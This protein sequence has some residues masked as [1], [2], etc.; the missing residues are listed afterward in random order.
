MTSADWILFL[1]LVALVCRYIY[2]TQFV[3]LPV[4]IPNYI[5]SCAV[6][7][8]PYQNDSLSN[9]SVLTDCNIT[10][11]QSIKSALLTEA[12]NTPNVI[13]SED[14]IKV[15]KSDDDGFWTRHPN[16]SCKSGEPVTFGFSRFDTGTWMIK[17]GNDDKCCPDQEN[18]R[19][20]L[21]KLEIPEPT[22]GPIKKFGPEI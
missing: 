18:A 22:Y 12:E 13:P 15:L 19:W 14:F 7:T 10:N 1:V 8:Y 16:R 20:N 9:I 6:R 17:F 5:K 11:V 4:Y 2:L 3:H 21:I